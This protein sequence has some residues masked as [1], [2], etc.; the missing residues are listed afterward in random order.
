MNWLR[1]KYNTKKKFF[2]YKA[3]LILKLIGDM[4]VIVNCTIYDDIFEYNFGK[5]MSY[6][7]CIAFNNTVKSL[8][9]YANKYKS[10]ITV[11]T[12]DELEGN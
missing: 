3:K 9:S 10:G 8:S 7:T 12:I 6:K 4:P 11:L 5:T 2:G 1:F